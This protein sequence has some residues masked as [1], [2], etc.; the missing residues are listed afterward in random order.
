MLGPAEALSAGGAGHFSCA[1]TTPVEKIA[2]IERSA[3]ERIFIRAALH[4]SQSARITKASINEARCIRV[5]V[6]L[7]Q[8]GV[9]G[10]GGYE[11]GD[12]GVGV[13]P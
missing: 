7:L 9:F 13:F 3:M 12:A 8:L 11:D 2:A 10:F 1:H 5:K 6:R 4:I